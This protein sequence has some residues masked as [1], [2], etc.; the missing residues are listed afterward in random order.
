MERHVL[1]PC[2]ADMTVWFKIAF[3]MVRGVGWVQGRWLSAALPLLRA[4]LDYHMLFCHILHCALFVI[5]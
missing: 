4:C 5:R 1:P 3:N 2:K